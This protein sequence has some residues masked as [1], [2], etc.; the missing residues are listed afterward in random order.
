MGGLRENMGASL[1]ANRAICGRA[2]VI[3]T[4]VA[5]MV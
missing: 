1:V 2:A 4:V 5:A 3:D